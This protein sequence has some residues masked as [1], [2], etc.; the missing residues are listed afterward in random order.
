MLTPPVKPMLAKAAGTIP[1]GADLIF[2]PKW[3][4]FRCL[5]FR[6]GSEVVLQSRSAKPLNRYF[7]EMVA[8]LA[9][10]LP[11]RV[12][13][14]GEL[15][16]GK[17]GRLDFDALSERIHPAASRVNLLAEQTPATFVAF[18]VLQLPSGPVLESPG[19]ERREMLVKLVADTDSVSLTPAT[20]DV[21]LARQW[22][23]LFEG[24]GLDGVIGK[25]AQGPY[26]PDKRTMLKFKH[27]R[28]ADCVVA[29]LRWY[30]D[31]EPG[32]SV[33]SL[34]LGLYDEKGVLHNVG[35]VGSFPAERRRELA[36]ELAE[37]MPGG[38]DDHP[39]LGE[40]AEGTRVPGE[41]NRWRSAQAA[42]VPLRRERVVE[43]AY[44][45]TEGGHPGRFRHTAQFIR[46]RPDRE[47]ASCGYEQLEEP[48]RYDLDAVLKG[49][50]RGR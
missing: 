49:E 23:T 30:K 5:V 21:E 40:V 10:G 36:V 28:T 22:F 45:H 32:T 14:D 3:D 47:A 48:A 41:I 26:T 2:E 33:G 1:D 24:A 43:V 16:V 6:D 11:D 25:P 12:V 15:V 31:T 29:G 18:D 34:L 42:W 8:R 19:I 4:G 13:L 7:P 20:Q 38:E 44:E 37:L 17:A 39:W 50:V 27:S 9:A 46:W 35:V